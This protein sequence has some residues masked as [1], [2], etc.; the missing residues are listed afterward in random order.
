MHENNLTQLV[1]FLNGFDVATVHLYIE[2]VF[3]QTALSLQ[4]NG[5]RNVELSCNSVVF[6]WVH[7]SS[8]CEQSKKSCS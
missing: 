3:N 5:S 2:L 6:F 7:V 8:K 4:R 1:G